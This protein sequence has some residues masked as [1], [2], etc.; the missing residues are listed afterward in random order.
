MEKSITKSLTSFLT[1]P[2]LYNTEYI[3]FSQTHFR[4]VSLSEWK[5]VFKF[6]TFTLNVFLSLLSKEFIC[7]DLRIGRELFHITIIKE[8]A[9]SKERTN[10]DIS[11]YKRSYIFLVT[12]CT[13]KI[14]LRFEI[15]LIYSNAVMHWEYKRK[16]NVKMLTA[17]FKWIGSPLKCI[18]F[19][20]T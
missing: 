19:I 11:P 20:P 6:S 13:I 3:P 18:F 14:F 10:E 5:R 7:S 17:E 2:K 16:K 9:V 15:S 4:N 12:H 8:F 1:K